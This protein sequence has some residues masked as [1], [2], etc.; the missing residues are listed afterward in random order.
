VAVGVAEFVVEDSLAFEV[1]E[2]DH[3]VHADVVGDTFAFVV[4]VVVFHS[5]VDLFGP[6]AS[7]E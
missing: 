2:V 3:V 1:V 7:T 6:V 4:G 5:R